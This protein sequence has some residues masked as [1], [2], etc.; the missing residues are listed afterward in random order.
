MAEAIKTTAG[1]DESAV[2]TEINYLEPGKPGTLTST[3]RI[4]KGGGDYP[5]EERRGRS[6]RH[7]HLHP[8]RLSYISTVRNPR[9]A[10]ARAYDGYTF[11]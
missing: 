1:E 8:H 4:R 9:T 10:E 7:R 2:T 5:G 6:A 11:S 3:A